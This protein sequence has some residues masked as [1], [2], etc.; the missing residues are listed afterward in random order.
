MST[1]VLLLL[2]S[3]ALFTCAYVEVDLDWQAIKTRPEIFGENKNC[4][5]KICLKMGSVADEQIFRFPILDLVSY[6]A[7]KYLLG[8]HTL[9]LTDDY[10]EQNENNLVR[11]LLVYYP[12]GYINGRI[13]NR[14]S[15]C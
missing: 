12:L 1:E 15:K 6:I 9:I 8:C 13:I 10:F 2:L 11:S 14:K 4:K 3:Q 5:T 7:R